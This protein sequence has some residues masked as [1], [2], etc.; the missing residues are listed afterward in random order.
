MRVNSTSGIAV[1]CVGTVNR[2]REPLENHKVI[3]SENPRAMQPIEPKSR[4][5]F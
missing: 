2:K 4:D 3:D 1:F 5:P